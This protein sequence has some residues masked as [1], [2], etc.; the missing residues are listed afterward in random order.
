MSLASLSKRV[1]SGFGKENV[2]TIV[3]VVPTLETSPFRRVYSGY[4][5]GFVKGL[6]LKDYIY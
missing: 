5:A 1:R 2:A 4:D 6:R 3:L